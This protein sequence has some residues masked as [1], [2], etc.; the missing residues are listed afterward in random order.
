MKTEPRV[1]D[2]RISE[3]VRAIESLEARRIRTVSGRI[4]VAPPV[5]HGEVW[6]GGVRGWNHG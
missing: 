3:S 6:A 1:W 2:T 5:G 4:R